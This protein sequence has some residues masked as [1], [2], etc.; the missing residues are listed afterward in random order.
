MIFNQYNNL[1]HR[2]LIIE[3]LR[4]ENERE[5]NKLTYNKVRVFS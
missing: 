2:L 3:S 4:L 5:V 1:G